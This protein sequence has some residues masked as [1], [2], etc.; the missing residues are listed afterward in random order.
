[1]NDNDKIYNELRK[2]LTD[3]EIA[4]SFIFPSEP[5]TEEERKEFSKVIKEHRK[6]RTEA[7]N[8]KIQEFIKKLKEKNGHS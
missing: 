8:E 3:E 2:E 5:L 1:M 6:N 4:E 7:E